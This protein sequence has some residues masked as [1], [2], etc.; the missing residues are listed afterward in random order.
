[1]ELHLSFLQ[2]PSAVHA[3]GHVI[4]I[5]LSVTQTLFT[6]WTG[7]CL[8]I[9]HHGFLGVQL[10]PCPSLPSNPWTLGRRSH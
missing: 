5:S 2:L 6:I 3:L 4:S 10:V 8:P 1:M 9:R 7:V